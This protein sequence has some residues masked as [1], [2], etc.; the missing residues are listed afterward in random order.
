MTVFFTDVNGI[1]LPNN[2]N[3]LLTF[4]LRSCFSQNYVKS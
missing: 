1:K 2:Y 4:M 3:L